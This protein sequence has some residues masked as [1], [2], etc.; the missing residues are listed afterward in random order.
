M[1]WEVFLRGG[2]VA[3]LPYDPI[4]DEV[5]LIEQL[6]AGALAAGR[7]AW[8]IETVAGVLPADR[9]PLD[10]CR[11]EVWEE[12]GLH[13]VTFEKLY[14]FMPSPASSSEWMTLYCAHVDASKAGGECGLE[15]EDEHVR[16]LPM[17]ADDAL[18]AMAAGSIDNAFTLI[19]LQ[20]LERNRAVLRDRWAPDNDEVRLMA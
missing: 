8:T 2:A 9:D 14:E 19:A 12:T 13:A 11:Q 1:D 7:N 4:R 3:V 20:W 16:V 17:A 10:V 18:A 5:V 6:R 15:E